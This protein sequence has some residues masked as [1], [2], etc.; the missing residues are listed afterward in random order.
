MFKDRNLLVTGGTGSIGSS[1]C[2]YFN[3]NGCEEI[4]STTTN[5]NKIKS[6]QD[7]IK[8]KK[9]D[10]NNLENLNLDQLFDF[11]I[12]Y[13]VLNAGLN[14]D[15]IFLRM[16]LEDWN[17][18]INVNLN[19]SFH[20]LKH[21][22]K[23]MVKKKFGRIVFISS[24]VAHTGN[25]GQVNYTA[26]KAAISGMVKS[27]A[28]ELSTRNITVNSVAPGFIQ[29][30]MTDKLNNEQKNTILDKIPMKKLGDS[31]DIAKAV[32]FLCSDNANYIT[33]QTLHV[34]GGLALI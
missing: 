8:F 2:N 34:N 24:V 29:S 21:F 9:L 22:T 20:L 33:G 31:N 27:L 17:S 1:I 16:S 12:D 15:N 26:S 4:Y 28:L 14:K 19:S 10:F 18:V 7:Y 25:P 6:D 32:G 23:K 30:N 11:D 3:I 5:T 13:L